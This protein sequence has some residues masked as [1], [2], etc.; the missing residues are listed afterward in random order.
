MGL[1]DWVGEGAKWLNERFDDVEHWV[2]D[3]WHGNTGDQAVPAPELVQKV[4]ASQGAQD[5]H[6]GAGRA[7]MLARQN[8]EMSARAQQLSAG[9]E[10]AWTGG[11]ADVARARIKP[12]TDATSAAAQTY[13]SN[14]QNLTDLAHGFDEMKAALQPMPKTPPH[15]NFLDTAT[16]WDTDTEDQINT[17]NR[18]AR[19]NLDRYHGYQQQA[20]TSGQGLKTDYGQLNKF[21]GEVS[22]APP[23][24]VSSSP[25]RHTPTGGRNRHSSARSEFTGPV[26][27]GHTS[28]PPAEGSV[29][30]VH[31]PPAGHPLPGENPGPGTP[32][33]GTRTAGYVPPSLPD[34]RPGS[35]PPLPVPGAGGGGS[36]WSGSAFVPGG[37]GPGS[38]LS[39]VPGA[40]GVSVPGAGGSAGRGLSS[41]PGGAGGPV[42]R[43]LPNGPGGGARSGAGE[44]GAVRGSGGSAATTGA[45]GGAGMSGMGAPGGKGKGEGDKEHQRKYGVDDDSAFSL[46]DDDG[47]RL[48]DPRTGLPPT[49]PTIGG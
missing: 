49:P 24:P 42:G 43:G 30:N 22:I 3:V 11:G 19:E 37:F 8:D 18:M 36:S 45:R 34:M 10:S 17:Y 46:T 29:P 44:E 26:G 2:S 20:Q 33:G 4:L 32:F 40:S 7:T 25:S 48:V 28:P 6:Q 16:P 5:W 39:G 9:L 38:S 15:K 31:M 41:G 47:D 13:T 14:G 12:L 27:A 1:F 35:V 23:A 21:D